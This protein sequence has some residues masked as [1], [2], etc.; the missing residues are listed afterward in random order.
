MRAV[1][2]EVVLRRPCAGR[3]VAEDFEVVDRPEPEAA[4]GFVTVRSL[5][6]ALDPYIGTRLRGRHMG[7]PAP[8]PGENLPGYAVGEV[9]ASGDPDLAPGDLVVGEM[10]WVERGRMAATAV[11]KVDPT[12]S[13]AD[14][15]GLLGLPG[16]TA[17]AGVTQLAKITAGDVFSVDAAAGAV[18]GTA[19]QIARH[20]GARTVGI[21][22]GA[23]KCALVRDL[24]GFDAAID[25]RLEGWVEAYG[26]AVGKGPTAHFENVGVSVLAPVLQRLQSYG[27]IV[28][29]GLAEHYHADGP[30]AQLPIGPLVGKRA[31]VFGLV[32]YDFFPRLT[33][34]V[35]MARPWIEAGT[36]TLA[37]DIGE[38]AES[39]PGH[40]ERLLKGENQGRALVQMSPS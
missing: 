27:R 34:W 25:Y 6:Q 40:F 11:R 26:A 35:A 2:R 13:A 9:L 30:P 18:G 8:A 5:Y 24:Y 10:G 33:E 4:T 23:E 36:L 22:G 12:L 3:P 20:L 31:Q 1:N 38:G 15:L 16:L 14:H 37:H 7:E 19:G 29:C 28:L 17:W 32:V 21:A 39:A